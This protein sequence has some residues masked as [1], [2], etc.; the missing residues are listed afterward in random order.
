[1]KSHRV[2]GWLT[3]DYVV[4]WA[5]GEESSSLDLVY[6]AMTESQKICVILLSLSLTSA[7][8]I[9]R[10]SEASVMTM[11]KTIAI[12]VQRQASVSKM[13]K[14]G[15]NQTTLVLQFVRQLIEFARKMQ[16]GLQNTHLSKSDQVKQ[17]IL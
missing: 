13:L 17:Y 11:Y 1:M 4:A 16:A 15:V 6:I 7:H 8:H 14:C 10:P 3:Q 12:W 5:I 9:H 2:S